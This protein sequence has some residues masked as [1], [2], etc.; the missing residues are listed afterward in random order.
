MK[1]RVLVIFILVVLTLVI[2]ISSFVYAMPPS[3]EVLG[4]IQRGE[5]ENPE[6]FKAPGVDEPSDFNMKGFLSYARS[7]ESGNSNAVPLKMLAVLVGFGL[8]L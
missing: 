5:I 8:I 4:K 7:S 1:K 3:E 2:F 6:K